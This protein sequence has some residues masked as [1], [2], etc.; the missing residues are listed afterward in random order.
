MPTRN[1]LSGSVSKKSTSV[2]LSSSVRANGSIF[3]ALQ[4][5][6]ANVGTFSRSKFH[7]SFTRP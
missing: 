6:F 5:E 4:L 7:P 2:R 1:G 3:G